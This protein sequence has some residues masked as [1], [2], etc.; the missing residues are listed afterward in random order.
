MPRNPAFVYEGPGSATIPVGI[1]LFDGRRIATRGTFVRTPVTS[2]SAADGNALVG[3]TSWADI[4]FDV[5]VAEI[6]FVVPDVDGVGLLRSMQYRVIR[7]QRH[8]GTTY[9]ATVELIL[10]DDPQRV[11]S[12]RDFALGDFRRGDFA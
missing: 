5:D 2:G 1:I 6:E 10:A 9:W 7:A 8:H 4:P 11:S 12:P 3:I